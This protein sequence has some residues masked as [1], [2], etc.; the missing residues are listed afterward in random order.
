MG[1]SKSK[2]SHNSLHL[3]TWVWVL[4]I[5]GAL[6]RPQQFSQCA[7]LLT[8]H[9]GRSALWLKV[10]YQSLWLLPINLVIPALLGSQ[11]SSGFAL[12]PF[13]WEHPGARSAR[14]P[15]RTSRGSG[16]QQ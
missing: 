13:L 1:P 11:A 9:L 8:G 5:T 7:V 10:A 4:L 12:K 3:L 15:E 6:L 2:T 14:S 16:L